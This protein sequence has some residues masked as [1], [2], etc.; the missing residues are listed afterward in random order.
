MPHPGPIGRRRPRPPLGA[1]LGVDRTPVG[2]DD[3]LA[4]RKPQACS[5][6][7]YLHLVGGGARRLFDLGDLF[8]I[9]LDRPNIGID[10]QACYE[11]NCQER[12]ETE[13]QLP[14]YREP[15]CFSAPE[16]SSPYIHIGNFHFICTL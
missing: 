5:D 10:D 14:C 3:P 7:V 2:L 13:Q 1:V 9:L 15:H 11:K 4:D 6:D 8:Q 12:P 16:I